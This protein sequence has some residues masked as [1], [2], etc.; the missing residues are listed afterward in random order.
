M[1]IAIVECVAATM[2]GPEMRATARCRHTHVNP[3][4]DVCAVTEDSVCVDNAS[5]LHREVQGK[6]VNVV[7]PALTSA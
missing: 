3:R 5:V 2:A 4:M 7:Q 6:R 1:A